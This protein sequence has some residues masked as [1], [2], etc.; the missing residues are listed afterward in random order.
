MNKV[1]K[2]HGYLIR[3]ILSIY[4]IVVMSISCITFEFT[5]NTKIVFRNKLW[6]FR[7]SSW[8]VWLLILTVSQELSF[9]HHII[10]GLRNSLNS[11][12]SLSFC[13]LGSVL[14]L[15]I[16]L[17]FPYFELSLWSKLRASLNI[18]R[19]NI[20]T[21]VSCTVLKLTF[22]HK[23]IWRW[24]KFLSFSIKTFIKVI[25]SIVGLTLEFTTNL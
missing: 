25:L 19:L 24:N 15:S 8:N 11:R 2:Y 3:C 7:Q 6:I 1:N 9:R 22:W 23:F 14:R 17:T 16:K 12:V 20:I 18:V 21:S 13:K 5:T 10:F 4:D